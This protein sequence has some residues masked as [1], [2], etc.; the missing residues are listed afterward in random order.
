[1]G[2]LHDSKAKVIKL[3]ALRLFALSM[4]I[5]PRAVFPSSFLRVQISELILSQCAGLE[6]KIALWYYGKIITY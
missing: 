1:M 4:I 6:C 2:F 5:C 3:T